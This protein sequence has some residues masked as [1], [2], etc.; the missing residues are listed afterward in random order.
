MG[1]WLHVMSN[2]SVIDLIVYSAL[3]LIDI[4]CLF[5]TRNLYPL[6]TVIQVRMPLSLSDVS[7]L[8]SEL[9]EG[10]MNSSFREVSRKLNQEGEWMFLWRGLKMALRVAVS[11][12]GGQKHRIVHFKEILEERVLCTASLWYTQEKQIKQQGTRYLNSK[13]MNRQRNP[14]RRL[15]NK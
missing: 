4:S 1:T 7:L 11:G 3:G 5:R 10:D 9:G 2:R 12:R 13:K 6:D 8:L 14:I 15:P